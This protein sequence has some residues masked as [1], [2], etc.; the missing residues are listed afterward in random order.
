[1]TEIGTG[2]TN[3]LL[4]GYHT[5][6]LSRD[7]DWGYFVHALWDVPVASQGGYRPGQEIDAAAGVV[8]NGWF[9]NS[10]KIR[11]SP[12]L[13]VLAGARAHDS[14]PASNAPNSGYDRVLV[15]PGVEIAAGKWNL[16][17]DVELPI[18]QHVVGNQL[19]A[20]ALVKVVVSR[21]F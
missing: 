9:V 8:Y 4:G 6:A 13:Q 3:L 19:T 18:Y 20:P 1:D 10:G 17:G 15:S 11:V 21:A 16:Y 14:G 7:G 2:S 5:G 12:V